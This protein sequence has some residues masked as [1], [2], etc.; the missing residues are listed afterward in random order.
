MQTKTERLQYCQDCRSR[1]QCH[2]DQEHE[3]KCKPGSPLTINDVTI[4]ELDRFTYLGS[5]V[6]KTRGTDEDVKAR[7]N[8]AR[9]AFAPETSTEE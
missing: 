5:I 8:K 4:E 7:I 9:Q 1:E 2:K 3:N 6:R